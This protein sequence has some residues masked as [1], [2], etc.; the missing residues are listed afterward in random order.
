MPERFLVDLL[1]L[2][3]AGEDP[4]VHHA[5]LDAAVLGL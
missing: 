1:A 4:A 2:L 5:A 3:Q